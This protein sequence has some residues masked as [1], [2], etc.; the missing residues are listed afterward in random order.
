MA[1]TPEQIEETFNEICER[2]SN[3]EAVRT[4]LLEETMPSS[5]TFYLWLDNDENKS[6]Q[7]ARACEDRADAIFDE[8]L[9]I[10]DEDNADITVVGGQAVVN[11]STIQRS[12]LKYDARKWVVSKLNPKK[13]G[14]K[15]DVTS[16]G[17]KMQTPIFGSNPLDE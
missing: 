16:G 12:R 7:Y 8:I 10:A 11:G 3:G 14:D 15:I 4:I 6:K 2:I 5:Q 13:Y 1:Y 9:V 17:E